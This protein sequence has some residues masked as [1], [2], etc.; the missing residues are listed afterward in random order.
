MLRVSKRTTSNIFKANNKDT[1]T[2][3]GASVVKG[4]LQDKTITSQNVSSEGQV[5]NFFYSV[6]KYVPF[7]SYTRYDVM[8]SIST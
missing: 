3:S 2:M 8:M 4:Y 7:S 5:K 1:T 6:E